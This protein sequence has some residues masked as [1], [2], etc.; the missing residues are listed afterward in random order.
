M[1]KKNKQKVI[2]AK[3]SNCNKNNVTVCIEF[4]ITL[5]RSLQ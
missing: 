2:S 4:L 5:N 3:L 1:K